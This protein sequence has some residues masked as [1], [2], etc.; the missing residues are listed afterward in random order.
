[1]EL[2]S[3]FSSQTWNFFLLFL[4][5]QFSDERSELFLPWQWMKPNE[6]PKGRL[7]ADGDPKCNN[8]KPFSAIICTAFAIMCIENEWLTI[9]FRRKCIPIF[10][11]PL[12]ADLRSSY[13]FCFK[14]CFIFDNY[15]FWL[16]AI[17]ACGVQRTSCIALCFIFPNVIKAHWKKIA[18]AFL[19]AF[20]CMMHFDFHILCDS[21]IHLTNEKKFFSTFWKFTTIIFFRLL[22]HSATIF[23]S[24]FEWNTDKLKNHD[25]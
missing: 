1:M 13:R 8:E 15:I 25:T 2:L 23:S 24:I 22:F 4:R 5:F 14:F 7:T 6:M 19:I 18:E 11:L 3:L 10:I 21:F 12:S 17:F 9:Y 20:Q 16:S